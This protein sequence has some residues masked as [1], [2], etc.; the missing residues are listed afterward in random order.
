MPNPETLHGVTVDGETAYGAWREAGYSSGSK[1]DQLPKTIQD[2]WLKVAMAVL[3]PVMEVQIPRIVASMVKEERERT[4]PI[5]TVYVPKGSTATLA[6]DP[7]KVD[8]HLEE[9]I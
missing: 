6:Y 8:V 1:W 5:V 4:K 2:V 3:R 9:V 7:S